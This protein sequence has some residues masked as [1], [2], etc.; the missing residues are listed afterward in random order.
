MAIQYTA[1]F[2]FLVSFTLTVWLINI[3][4][5]TMHRLAIKQYIH[6]LAPKQH[7]TKT[8]TPTMGGI[9]PI[10]MMLISALVTWSSQ[11]ATA[12]TCLAILIGFTCIGLYDDYTKFKA[13]KNQGIRASTKALAQAIVSTAGML[14]LYHLSPQ[15]A[16][17]DLS[18]MHHTGPTLHLGWWFV[19]W[20]IFVCIACSNA[21][22]LTDGLDGLASMPA[23][24][25]GAGLCILIWQYHSIHAQGVILISMALIGGVLGFL[26]HNCFPARIFMGDTGSLALGAWIGLLVLYLQ[27]PL[28]SII[29]LAAIALEPLSV[30]IQVL[31]F[32]KTGKRVFKMAPIHHHFE[33]NGYPEQRIVIRAWIIQMILTIIGVTLGWP[34]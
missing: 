28:V 1:L 17:L 3:F 6:D 25:I 23:I 16:I 32:K 14:T 19:P 7:K 9:V 30:T 21:L 2:L 33:L 13:K 5:N 10:L 15:L 20:G 31:V 8:D 29:M 18:I 4:I 22:N 12:I 24:I 27:K 11:S 26:W 34:S